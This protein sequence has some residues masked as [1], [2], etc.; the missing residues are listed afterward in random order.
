MVAHVGTVAF[1]GLEA[2]RVD[3]QVQISSGPAGFFTVGLPDKAVKESRERVQATLDAIGLALPP[4]RIVVNLSPADLPKEGSHYDLPIALGVLAAMGIIAS[5]ALDGFLVVGELGL[6]GRLATVPGVLLAALHAAENE[7][8]LVCPASQGGEAAWAGDVD[9]IAAPDLLA[10]LNHL[11]GTQLLSPP[12]RSLAELVRTG[13]DMAEIKGQETAKRA[14]EIAAAGGHNLLMSGP[15]GSGKS[16]LAAALPG[17]LPELTPA[18][19]LE[20]SM[21]ASMAGELEGGRLVRTRPFRSPH[22]SASMPALVGGGM[23]AR[24]GE[25]SLAHLGVLFLDELPEFQR[26]AL[27]SLRQPLE[28]GT[29][30]VARAAA[31]V[32]YPARV[33]LIA[34]MNPCRCGHLGDPAQACSRAPKCAADYQSRISGPLLDRIDLH[35]DVPAVSAADLSLP[36]PAETSADVAARV[37]AARAVQ[38]ARYAGHAARTNAEADGK[39]LATT[40]TPDQAGAKLLAQAAESLRLSARGYHRVLRVART[41]AD[42]AGSDGVTRIHI[43]EAL[44][45]RRRAPS[46]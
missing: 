21:V 20:V 2:R 37:K 17:I 30:M 38:T 22:H 13:P 43:A 3:V 9:V 29:V 34:A 41:L 4:R 10:L 45:Y 46:N 25:V 6:D 7:M 15:P 28:T 23:K 42:L 18:E 36:P 11:K 44:S 26:G 32:S 14:I 16:L 39:L 31:H 12:E 1:L 8:G 33:Q 19:A 27:D 40:A 5:D 24:P 35:V